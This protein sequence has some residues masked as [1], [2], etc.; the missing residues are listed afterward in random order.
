MGALDAGEV[1]ERALGRLVREG[2]LGVAEDLA[3]L[4]G[5]EDGLG[6]VAAAAHV[7]LEPLVERA[8]VGLLLA[9]DVGCCLARHLPETLGEL[10]A[11]RPRDDLDPGRRLDRRRLDRRQ[12]EHHPRVAPG[13]LVA[14]RCRPG[15]AAGVVLGDG[16]FELGRAVLGRPPLELGAELVADAMS[17]PLRHDE[18]AKRSL[19]GAGCASR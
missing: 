5:D 15:K 14:A 17:A 11:L 13:L 3:L 8:G 19:G 18:R 7:A 12:V 16:A 4:D 10:G 1:V 6:P 9:R 2:E